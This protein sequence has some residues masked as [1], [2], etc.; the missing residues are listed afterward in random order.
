MDVLEGITGVCVALLSL[1]GL[2]FLMHRVLQLFY[3]AAKLDSHSN[4]KN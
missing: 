3:I 1:K 4:G 2:P